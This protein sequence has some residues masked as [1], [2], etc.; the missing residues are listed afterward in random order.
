MAY[1]FKPLEYN[2]YQYEQGVARPVYD[3]SNSAWQGGGGLT[4][5]QWDEAQQN[6]QQSQFQDYSGQQFQS[7]FD[8]IN[9][10][11][12]NPILTGEKFQSTPQY[13]P[14]QGTRA[15]YTTTNTPEGDNPIFDQ[16][17]YLD[18][19][20]GNINDYLGRMGSFFGN[21]GPQQSQSVQQILAN[22]PGQ[23]PMPTMPSVGSNLNIGGGIHTNNPFPSYG[24]KSGG[25]GTAPTSLFGAGAG[26]A[27]NP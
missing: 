14:Y 7:L 21:L 2:P 25:W 19:Q 13:S 20:F 6:L 24:V 17:S 4:G 27:N 3:S 9:E 15:D 22:A 26:N 1:Y 10:Y 11:G 23:G 18:A 12:T 5:P 16:Q 8:T